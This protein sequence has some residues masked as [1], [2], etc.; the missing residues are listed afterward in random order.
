MAVWRYRDRDSIVVPGAAWR[1]SCKPGESKQ[2]QEGQPG[3]GKGHEKMM[4]L[5]NVLIVVCC[6]VSAM[7]VLYFLMIMPRV[8]GKPDMAYFQGWFYAHR[9][10]HDNGGDAPENSMKAFERAV[11]AG[12]GIEMDV[13]LSKDGVPVVFHDDT[14][15]RICGVEGKLCDYTYEEL[16]KF[17]LCGTDQRIPKFE[18]AL[19]LVAGQVPLVVEMK[20]GTTD[21]SVC[22]A[23]DRLLGTYPGGYCMESFNP[24]A[25]YWYRRYR[26][27]VVRGQLSDGFLKEGS[28]GVFYF[29]LQ[30]LLFNWLGKPDFVAYN[31]HFPGIWSRRLCRTLYRN[32]AVAWTIRSKEELEAA[33]KQFDLFIFEGFTPDSAT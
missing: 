29:L 33:K 3:T 21:I 25:V 27:E 23:A 22:R 18:D 24:L 19:G 8:A 11:R 13:H 14:L 17:R 12:Y 20:A 6:C 1:D 26:K 10:L 31:H 15:E 2:V 7:A 28:R 5:W 16:Q 9:G 4:A 32:T 30:N